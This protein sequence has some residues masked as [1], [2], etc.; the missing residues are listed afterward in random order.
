MKHTPGKWE[1]DTKGN[2]YNESGVIRMNGVLIAKMVTQTT[3]KPKEVEANA[4][5]IAAAPEL[6]EACK[7][8]LAHLIS[9]DLTLD[10]ALTRLRNAILTAEGGKE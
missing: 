1:Y 10:M 7:G 2:Y 9:G 6:L 3:H 8:A 5:L 4:R